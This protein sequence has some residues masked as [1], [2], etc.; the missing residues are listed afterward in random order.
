MIRTN[1]QLKNIDFIPIVIYL[2]FAEQTG[3]KVTPVQL[4]AWQQ[5]DSTLSGKLSV[6]K[7]TL[8]DSER[9]LHETC[10]PRKKR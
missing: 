2:V 1:T 10:W 5:I 7:T 6:V 4:P 3:Q 8:E 9:L